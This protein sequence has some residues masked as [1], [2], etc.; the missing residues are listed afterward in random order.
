MLSYL[1]HMVQT[2]RI[3]IDRLDIV[4]S[5]TPEYLPNSGGLQSD[6]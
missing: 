1:P 3:L 4:M 5:V 6:N 2:L